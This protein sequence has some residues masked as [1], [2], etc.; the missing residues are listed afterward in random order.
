MHD[1]RPGRA[2]AT[3]LGSRCQGNPLAFAVCDQG[4]AAPFT[5]LRLLDA[6]ARG[7]ACTRALLLVVEQATLHYLPTV[8]VRLPER[9]TAVGL[10]LAA[11]PTP[12]ITVRQRA[13]VPAE[14]LDEEVERL[15]SGHPDPV[16]LRG[17]SE[18][19]L[20]GLWWE[21]AT[22][23]ETLAA[24]GKRVVLADHDPSVGLL[25]VAALDLTTT[26]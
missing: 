19:P 20:T 24:Q 6:Y 23:L 7:G 15:C 2:T 5:A 13:G 3:Y 14:E 4:T 22:G 12:A 18:L 17:A 21:L 26:S 25:S 9:H 10:L 16:V 8:P 1:V 11:G